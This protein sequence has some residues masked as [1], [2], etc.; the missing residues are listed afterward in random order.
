MRKESEIKQE[1]LAAGLPLDRIYTRVIPY[2]SRELD[3]K[4]MEAF[5]KIYR[6]ADNDPNK[7][8]IIKRECKKKKIPLESTDAP[9]EVYFTRSLTKEETQVFEDI[10]NG[11]TD[12]EKRKRELPSVNDFIEA[13]AA[14][15][16]GD[17][18]PMNEYLEK[19]KTINAKYG[20]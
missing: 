6:D 12:E 11:V 13:Y 17:I 18:N 19:V 8:E 7:D 9:V 14:E 3:K 20:K 4:E 5:E 16:E 2:F 15:Q 1:I 10:Y